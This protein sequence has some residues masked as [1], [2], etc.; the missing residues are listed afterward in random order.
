[1]ALFKALRNTVNSMVHSLEWLELP[2][3]KAPALWVLMLSFQV[4]VLLFSVGVRTVL[5]SS[6]PGGWERTPLGC[7]QS[8]LGDQLWWA[9]Q[10]T[11]ERSEWGN[12]SE[13]TSMLRNHVS[14]NGVLAKTKTASAVWLS[15]L[16][17]SWSS[18]NLSTLILSAIYWPRFP[19]QPSYGCFM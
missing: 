17:D 15:L 6:Q 5:V 8:K 18:C 9:E 11:G 19:K 2:L 3:N 13:R 12:A 4:T 16:Q 10:Q 7:E 1:M 14:K